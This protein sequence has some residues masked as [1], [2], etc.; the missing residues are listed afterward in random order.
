MLPPPS[1]PAPSSSQPNAAG[2]APLPSANDYAALELISQPVWIFDIDRRHVLWANSPA[3]QVWKA[4]SLEELQARDLGRDMSATVAHRL[5]QYQRDF[6][7]H[8]AIF[9]EQ[10]TLYPV[11]EA[12]ALHVRFSGHRLADGRMAMM[13]EG[14]PAGAHAPDSVRAVEA[15]LHTTLMISLYDLEGHPLY[16]NPAARDSTCRPDEC[17]P[18]RLVDAEDIQLLHDSLA[19]GG[20]SSLTLRVHTPQ[21]VRWHEV[22]ARR[23][24]DAVSGQDALL[25]S[26]A[27]VTA[28]KDTEAQVRHLA[29][30]DPLTGLPNRA[31]VMARFADALRELGAGGAEAAV[32]FI[33]L[34]NFKDINDTLGHAAGDELLVG[35]ARRLRDATRTEDLVARLGGDEFMVL[36]RSSDI[37]GDVDHAYRRIATSLA[38]PLNVRGLEVRITPSVGVSLFPEHACDIETLLRHA[39]L[40]MYGAKAEGRNRMVLYNESMG[41]EL[42]A[43]TSLEAELRLALERGEFE[44]HYQPRMAVRSRSILGAEALVRWRHPVHGLVGPDIFIPMSERL[45]LIGRLGMFVFEAAVRQQTEWAARGHDL[46]ISVN[47]SPLQLADTHL[48]A[49]MAAVLRR[50]GCEPSRIELEV[51]E[52]MLLGNEERPIAVL[53]AIEALGMSI[54]LDDFG[55]GYSNLAYLQRY[56]LH[57]LK[58]DKTFIQAPDVD[59]PLAEMIVSLCRLLKLNVVAEGVETS[60]QLAWVARREIAE[61]Q[62]YHF[63]PPVPAP[64]FEALLE[65]TPA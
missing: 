35:V 23:C 34:D 45:G 60:E 63:S 53:K 59:R 54:A 17:L 12:V 58:I 7:A 65:A 9:A 27:D 18:E 11:G 8:N 21:G 61:Y 25:L 38:A 28:I 4:R 49:R 29:L 40:A 48:V 15:L 62:G 44:V 43:R 64:H 20:G 1:P 2:A 37:R 46:Q 36:L 16:R 56:P 41:M 51:T 22:T 50:Y 42:R 13:C 30:H 24:H 10:W 39:D 14:Q 19:S 55:T 57:T 6:E 5:A 52:S 32:V 3:L 26:E 47:L 31:Q 33:D